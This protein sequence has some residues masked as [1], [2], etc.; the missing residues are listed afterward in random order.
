MVIFKQA[1]AATPSGGNE[2]AERIL[3]LSFVLAIR[4]FHN[5]FL[6]ITIPNSQL[7]LQYLT[8]VS[9]FVS[10]MD[11]NVALHYFIDAFTI[12]PAS[13]VTHNAVLI[14]VEASFATSKSRS[15][16]LDFRMEIAQFKPS[17]TRPGGSD[18][19]EV[20]SRGRYKASRLQMR[21]APDIQ[22]PSPDVLRL[23]VKRTLSRLHCY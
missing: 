9:S 21:K 22:D 17:T 1:I 18:G 13:K 16:L 15:I 14:A 12:S 11:Q 5:R 4:S 3:P 20:G 2:F 6:A 8:E 19:E 10:C 7:F 23:G